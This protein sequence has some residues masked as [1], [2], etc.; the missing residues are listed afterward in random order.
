MAAAS[1]RDGGPEESDVQRLLLLQRVQEL[2]SKGVDVRSILDAASRWES[3]SESQ[4]ERLA[5]RVERL[6]MEAGPALDVT[7]FLD[8][9]LTRI[10]PAPGCLVGLFLAFAGSWTVALQWRRLGRP[11]TIIAVA[12]C[13]GI[14]FLVYRG[15]ARLTF[16]SWIRDVLVPEAI[17][18]QIDPRLLLECLR[19]VP[20]RDSSING[21]LRDL[22]AFVDILETHVEDGSR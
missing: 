2:G 20:L 17:E 13:V 12:A 4:R 18:R 11:W 7:R 22:A 19:Q 14:G 1:T 15:I 5:S 16:Q 6:S 9:I 21:R 3:L 10:P 8:T